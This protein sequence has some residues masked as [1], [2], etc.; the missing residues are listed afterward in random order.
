MTRSEVM[1]DTITV[2]LGHFRMNEKTRVAEF[3]D[4]FSQ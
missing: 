3:G 1:E 2:L 4:L